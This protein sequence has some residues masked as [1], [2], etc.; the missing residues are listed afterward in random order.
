MLKTDLTIFMFLVGCFRGPERAN[1][2]RV[3]SHSQSFDAPF[4]FSKISAEIGKI[5]FSTF[6]KKDGFFLTK[7]Y[8]KNYSE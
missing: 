1:R 6:F 5:R 4:T 7:Y 2:E 8:R 3:K